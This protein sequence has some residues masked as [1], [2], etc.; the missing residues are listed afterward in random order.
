MNFVGVDI[1]ASNTRMTNS[2]YDFFAIPNNVALL[3]TEV[4]GQTVPD[5]EVSKVSPGSSDIT[6][7]LEVIIKGDNKEA[8]MFP[9]HVLMGFM[10]TS[11]GATSV[12]TSATRKSRQAINY[13][14][15]ITAAAVSKMRSDLENDLMLIVAVPPIEVDVAKEEMQKN[16]LGKWTVEF[17]KYNGGTTV[18]FTV[19]DLI[20]VP[21]GAMAMTSFFLNPYNTEIAE[22]KDYQSKTLLSI[23]IGASTTDLAIV[24]S[25]RVLRK[26]YRTI[27]LGGNTADSALVNQILAKYDIKVDSENLAKGMQTGYIK[28]GGSSMLNVSDCVI[29]AKQELA[30]KIYDKMREYF[31][32]VDV[33]LSSID[34]IVV[35]GGGSMSSEFK[36]RNG[37][38]VET[39]VTSQP[40]S[41]Y[42]YE[43]LK[44]NNP[45]INIDV[46]SHS[47]NPRLAN[48]YGICIIGHSLEHNAKAKQ[49]AVVTQQPAPAPQPLTMNN[50]ASA[51][52]ATPGQASVNL[53][54]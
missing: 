51:N 29:K 6:E 42:L 20:T 43:I 47:D 3:T 15:V 45:N 34:A 31:D 41:T 28:N 11:Y 46:V 37:D 7:S 39:L 21:E 12:P 36:Q 54:V 4:N 33:Q 24:Q 26:T 48:I 27:K 1:G 44:K 38:T 14:S 32:E 40:M 53:T 18:E 25:K 23:D 16:L 35:S 49:G 9:V 17:P 2:K 10:G 13:I 22:H 8:S 30:A 52:G 50:D 5:M 19:K